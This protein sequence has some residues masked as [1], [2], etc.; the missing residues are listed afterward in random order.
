MV[1]IEHIIQLAV[2]WHLFFFQRQIEM[3][4]LSVATHV[5][6]RFTSICIW[7]K[8]NLTIAIVPHILHAQIRTFSLYFFYLETTWTLLSMQ[9]VWKSYFSWHS[10]LHDT[11]KRKILKSSFGL[12]RY[13]LKS[14]LKFKFVHKIF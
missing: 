8:K 14:Y 7:K 9:K 1:Q 5:L 10:K 13:Y 12:P 11:H 4:F 2:V 3:S 6:K